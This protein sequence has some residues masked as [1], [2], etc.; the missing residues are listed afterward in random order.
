MSLRT[1]ILKCIL[2]FNTIHESINFYMYQCPDWRPSMEYIF[3]KFCCLTYN[4][5]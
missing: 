4:V 1:C 5:I 2:F 3:L